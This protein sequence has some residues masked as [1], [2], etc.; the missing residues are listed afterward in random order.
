MKHCLAS[1]VETL[2]SRAILAATIELLPLIAQLV[3]LAE[4]IAE[5]ARRVRASLIDPHRD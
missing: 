4:E 2:F 3:V 1:R 5:I